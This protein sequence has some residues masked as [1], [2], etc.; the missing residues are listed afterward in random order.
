MEAAWRLYAEHI[1][2]LYP[3]VQRL[4]LHLKDQ[5][6]VHFE[7]DAELEAVLNKNRTTTLTAWFAYNQQNTD[8][9]RLTYQEFPEHFTFDHSK[10]VWTKR[11]RNALSV[12][13]IYMASP[14]T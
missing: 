2:G 8:G 14:G 11:I 6:I 13:R 3:P 7:D 9:R 1:D 4:A 12:G 10:R 5:E